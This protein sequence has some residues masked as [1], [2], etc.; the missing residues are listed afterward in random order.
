MRTERNMDR[1]HWSFV[2]ERWLNTF[3]L[4]PLNVMQYFAMSPFY[5]PKSNNHALMT[6][7]L[8][9]SALT[10]MQG[11]EFMLDERPEYGPDVFVIKKQNRISPDSV[12]V[13][14]VYFIVH[15]VVYQ[16]PSLMEVV[17]S[18]MHKAN[19]YLNRSLE[20]LLAE[21]RYTSQWGHS[22]F[23]PESSSQGDDKGKGQ[24]PTQAPRPEMVRRE[25]P[26]WQTVFDDLSSYVDKR[27]QLTAPAKNISDMEM[28]V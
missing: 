24:Y 22:L 14:E 12:R 27:L 5:D 7:N 25:M 26:P 1:K 3:G 4:G 2:D 8:D 10:R 18:R 20:V 17:A 19:V 9:L 23:E 13:L 11:L 16:S 28:A 6:Q 15:G 21:Q